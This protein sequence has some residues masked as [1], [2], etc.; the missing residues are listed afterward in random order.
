MNTF[1]MFIKL[2]LGEH[3][4]KL[5]VNRNSKLFLNEKKL[6]EHVFMFIKLWLNEFLVNLLVNK[7]SKLFLSERRCLR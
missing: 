3:L 4:V 6:N 2:W 5:L 7:F 1:F